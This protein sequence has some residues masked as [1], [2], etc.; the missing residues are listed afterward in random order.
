MGAFAPSPPRIPLVRATPRAAPGSGGQGKGPHFAMQ[1]TAESCC[2]GYGH[3]VHNGASGGPSS[4]PQAMAGPTTRRLALCSAG[5]SLD[6]IQGDKANPS[7]SESPPKTS[8][9]RSAQ[10]RLHPPRPEP[11]DTPRCLPA[12]PEQPSCGP[13]DPRRAPARLVPRRHS[14]ER[15]ADT[16]LGEPGGQG[17]LA[18][19]WGGW[20][21]PPR[22][23]L[24]CDPQGHAPA[25]WCQHHAVVRTGDTR[26]LRRR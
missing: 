17:R 22:W 15:G 4:R 14:R 6:Q 19:G 18:G 26:G 7:R 9:P 10:L 21:R 16:R 23:A 8:R 13:R 11:P 25:L 3:E 12:S 20:L 2:K 5:S 1:G 24:D